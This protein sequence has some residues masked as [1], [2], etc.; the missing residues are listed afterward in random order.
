MLG[1]F[2]FTAEAASGG[3]YQMLNHGVSTGALFCL[4]GFLYERRHTRRIGDY[5]GVAA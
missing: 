3:A 5:G 1:I 4:F 2:A